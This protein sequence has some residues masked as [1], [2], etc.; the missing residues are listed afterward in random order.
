MCTYHEL[1][2]ATQFY[3]WFLLPRA[4]EFCG[5]VRAVAVHL[6]LHTWGLCI[7]IL[8][9]LGPKPCYFLQNQYISRAWSSAMLRDLARTRPCTIAH[10]LSSDTHLKI[11][12][13][14]TFPALFENKLVVPH[15]MLVPAPFP[16]IHMRNQVRG[17][18]WGDVPNDPTGAPTH[19]TEAPP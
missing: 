8:M 1:H 6:Q 5:V 14:V 12:A 2:G 19:C 15:S 11:A 16:M 4:W 7:P 9:A 3:P 13:Y 18:G 17:R 10:I